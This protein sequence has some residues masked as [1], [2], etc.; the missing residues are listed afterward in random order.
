MRRFNMPAFLQ[1]LFKTDFLPHGVCYRW[2]PGVVWLHVVSDLL[3]TLAYYFIPFALIYIVRRRGDLVYP[4]M[5]LLFGLFI[6]ACGTTH[7]MA[8]LVVWQPWY[9]LDGVIKLIT[10]AAS[11]PT[12]IL[13]VRLAPA[14]IALPSPDRLRVINRQL[15]QEVADRKAAEAEVRR[16]NADLEHRVAERTHE[17]QVANE[18]LLQSE[19][20][21]RTILDSAPLLVYLK[22]PD[23]RY[24][25][26]NR[27]LERAFD[28]N[29]QE[30]IGR[31][32]HQIFP[33]EA[34]DAYRAADAD[35]WRDRQPHQIEE[36][37][38]HHGEV[39]TYLSVKFALFEDEKP[40]ALCGFSTNITDRKRAEQELK[41]YNA[42]LEQFAHVA[43]HDLQE[44]L[45]TVKSYAQMIAKRYRGTLDADADEFLGYITGGVE[46][47]S[48]LIS[49]LQELTSLPKSP[50]G[51]QI[52]DANV[53][54][55]K[56]LRS[57]E[58]AI[59]ETGT[60][61]RASTLPVVRANPAQLGQVLQNLVTNAIKY[62]SAEPPRINIDTLRTGTQWEFR[63]R[64]NGMGFD[65]KYADQIFG[66]FR[67]LHGKEIPG[68]GI[69]LAIVKKI[70]ESHGGR[71][72]ATSEPGRGAEFRFTLPAA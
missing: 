30:V 11:V 43:A 35:V 10:A 68:T 29:R 52:T 48:E 67:R 37:G 50:D 34:A 21:L 64:D 69:G 16:L 56:T 32:G 40:W 5:F 22:D 49:G 41:R 47:M 7:L 70:V 36:Y 42:E 26:I 66:V 59:A 12:A 19:N 1:N 72:W 20:R 9:R 71:I 63:V 8:V 17:L 65:M 13:L 4:W 55:Q 31:T 2:D 44:P 54:L 39:H 51:G 60:V 53:V 14:V 28:L 61:V 3:I 27:E 46:R 58:S 25:F 24:L 18:K 23:D 15:T 38:F 45:R 62:R 33:V 57:L 6:L